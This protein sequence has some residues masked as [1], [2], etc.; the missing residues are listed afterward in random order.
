MPFGDDDRRDDR[1]DRDDHQSQ[2]IT[3]PGEWEIVVLADGKAALCDQVISMAQR[4]E[5]GDMGDVQDFWKPR[6]EGVENKSKEEFKTQIFDKLN[7]SN[8]SNEKVVE[9]FSVL[10]DGYRQAVGR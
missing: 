3:N 4:G 2:V 7:G 9:R 1:D 5:F 6:K 10:R 8:F